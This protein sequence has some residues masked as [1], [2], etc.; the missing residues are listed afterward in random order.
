M[1]IV[2]MT[3]V[4]ILAIVL[5]SV[6]LVNFRMKNTNL[7]SQKNFYTA[8]TA[9]EEIRLG[10][11]DDMSV[12][13]GAAYTDT[14]Q[15]YTVLDAEGREQNFKDTFLREL[16]T[17][18]NYQAN[19]TYDVE[20]LVGF[21]KKTKYKE[22][23]GVGAKVTSENEPATVTADGLTLKNVTVTYYG[24][25]GYV[26]EIKTDICLN[27]PVINFSQKTETP[28]L[29]QYALVTKDHLDLL[30][31]L[32]CTIA[33][34]AYLG[35]NA[36]EIKQS[37]LSVMP[38]PESTGRGVIISKDMLKGDTAAELNVTGMEVWAK[39]LVID[40]SKIT[41]D[42]TALY[43]Q[44]DFILSNSLLT[45]SGA[46]LDGEFYGYGN[47]VTAKAADSAQE[48]TGRLAEIQKNPADYSSSI[49]IN[50][51]RS[52]LDLSGLD[53]MK[54]SGNSY[55]NGTEQKGL[56]SHYSDMN[57]EDVLMGESLS[58]RSDQIAYLVPAEC[59]APETKNGGTNP[60]PIDQYSLLL[61]ELTERYGDSGEKNLVDLDAKAIKYNSTLRGLG[62]KGWHLAAQQVNGIG[63]MI[64]VFMEFDSTDSTNAFFRSYYKT[65]DHA[66]LGEI[67]DLYSNGGIKLPNEVLNQTANDKFYFNG[68]ILAS[69]ASELYVSDKLG[70]ASQDVLD[71]LREEEKQYQDSYVALNTKLI[72]DYGALTS[73]EKGNSVYDNLVKSM[74]SAEDADYT[75]PAGTS[76]VFHSNTGEAAVVA[77]GD[78]TVNE[79]GIS[80]VAGSG[81][82]TL[83][84]VIASGDITVETDFTGLLIAGGTIHVK[85]SV[86][87][88]ADAKKAGMALLAKSNEGV[89]AYEYLVDGENYIV[90]GSTGGTMPGNYDGSSI[91]LGDYVTYENWSKQ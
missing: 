19:G 22:N 52:S 42:D 81:G 35:E 8:E 80:A 32:N 29:T 34:N 36:T 54:I 57:T 45:S 16:K 91:D 64:Y 17:E 38:Q 44:N 14:L 21:L 55:I 30:P 6:V 71:S 15:K 18:I 5:M 59:I 23:I 63:S 11:C 88:K 74:V 51:I 90:A 33:G 3:I 82:G 46:K 31:G 70:T 26:T 85:D 79:A 67:L 84:V 43:L 48:D 41:T 1:V 2:V 39:N 56:F 73:L 77:N 78:Y 28:D 20:H 37:K 58:I 24:E 87:L 13:L 12:A 89:R 61:T 7:S 60:M 4:T 75:I 47:I 50:G 86:T 65:A 69:D 27:Y 9:L 62:V 72:R 68:N 76:R 40:S 83:C 49:I 25:K 10:L 66:R 53:V